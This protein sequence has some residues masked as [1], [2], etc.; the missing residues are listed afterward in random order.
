MNI[1]SLLTKIGLEDKDVL[2][3]YQYGSRVY[4]TNLS[5]SDWD[6]IIVVNEK[7]REEFSDN[8]IN[9]FFYTPTEFEQKLKAHEIKILECYFL[10]DYLIWKELMKFSFTLNLSKLRASL[11]E[12]SSHS[13]VKGKKKILIE[14]DLKIGKKSIFH[15][16]RI[17]YF[18]IQIA[19]FG[20]ITNYQEANNLFYEI[21]NIYNNWNN[22]FETYQQKHN[23]L[24]SEFRIVAP[25]L[26]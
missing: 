17:I 14:N 15:S 25:K 23:K 16:F 5:D 9:V 1:K 8:L 24:M 21:L 3:I 2:N 7:T 20:R 10:P 19:S 13:W 22:V 6:F 4:Q 12:K 26:V 11:S 18:G